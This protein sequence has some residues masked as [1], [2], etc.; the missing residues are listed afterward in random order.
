[1]SSNA[2]TE[3]S[4]PSGKFYLKFKTAGVI[5]VPKSGKT[6]LGNLLATHRNVEYYE[7]PWLLGVL[8]AMVKFEMIDG[9]V[10]KDMYVTYLHE[11]MNDL[12]LLRQANFRPNDGSSIWTKK[13]AAE[14]FSRLVS[15]RS[16]SDVKNFVKKNNP[17]F[18][19]AMSESSLFNL[20]AIFDF[21]P[22]C[23]IIHM[24]RRGIDVAYQ[25]KKKGG[26]SDEQ[27]AKPPHA[28]VYR[29]AADK[30]PPFYM[31]CWVDPKDE[32]KFMEYSE[33]ER[34]LFY[35]CVLMEN[36]MDSYKK[37][38]GKSRR[39]LTI[40]FEDLIKNPRK[41]LKKANLFLN[42]EPTSLTETALRKIDNYGKICEKAPELPEELL[43][44]TKKIYK[45]FKYGW[46]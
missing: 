32:S 19:M 21:L 15:L 7:E 4:F 26:L 41:M 28:R 31:P 16:R 20:P 9:E 2:K 36:M 5:G 18:L 25:I 46:D 3:Y 27:L 43:I 1:M 11:L 24:V 33:Y 10:G 23:K 37:L 12:I 42:L 22:D 8:P 34:A 29:P 40:K 44:R 17:I 35:W 6:A 39:V 45:Y 30:H 38:K 13:T 14:I